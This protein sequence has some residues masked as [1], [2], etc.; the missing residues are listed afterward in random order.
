MS[1]LTATEFAAHLGVTRR[2]ALEILASGAVE[3]RRLANGLWL[4]DADSVHRYELTQNGRGRPLARGTAWALL[5]E[6]SGLH[7]DWVATRTHA[8]LRARIRESN[9]V[10]IATAV[11]GRTRTHRYRA[12]NSELAAA[13]LITTGRSAASLLGGDL[14]DDRRRTAGYVRTGTVSEY[15]A[16]HFMAPDLTGQDILYENT[17]PVHYNASAMPAA[18]V[19]ADLALSTDTRERSAGIAALESLRRSWLVRH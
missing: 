4:A 7:P 8:R 18:V 13:E 10:E 2:R 1:E 12:A 5:W 6:L 19:A 9:G 17:L 11:A 16:E 3:A 15:A 14:I